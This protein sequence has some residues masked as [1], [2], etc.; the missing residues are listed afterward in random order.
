M[1]KSVVFLMLFLQKA[2]EL[3]VY[4]LNYPTFASDITIKHASV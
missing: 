3:L 2:T 1:T 4:K